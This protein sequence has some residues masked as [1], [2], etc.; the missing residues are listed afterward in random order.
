MFTST[1]AWSAFEEDEKGTLAPGKLADLVVL[2]KD[3]FKVPLTEI[4]DSGVHSVCV[5]GRWHRDQL[6][7]GGKP[8]AVS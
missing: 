3:P 2:E 7:E 5:Q 6:A 8:G 4:K 1:G